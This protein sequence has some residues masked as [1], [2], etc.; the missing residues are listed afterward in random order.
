[1]AQQTANAKQSAANSQQLFDQYTNNYVP[2]QNQTI[3]D[4]MNLGNAQDQTQKAG[5]AG[6]QVQSSFAT[7]QGANQRAMERMGVNPGSGAALALGQDA[8]TSE[9]AQQSGAM[10]NA[11]TQAINAGITQRTAIANQGAGLVGASTNLANSATSATGSAL[12]AA[13]AQQ[14]QY[15]TTQQQQDANA[16]ANAQGMGKL[17]GQAVSTG[18]TNYNNPPP[19]QTV[20]GP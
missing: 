20:Y 2:V 8:A 16:A 5:V 1:M 10:N 11:R 17:I 19:K 13:D 3:T 18:I 14:S 6:A 7:Q 12:G 9:A 15:L 4:A